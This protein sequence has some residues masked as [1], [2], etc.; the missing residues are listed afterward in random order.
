MLNRFIKSYGLDKSY[1]YHRHPICY[2]Y[3]LTLFLWFSNTSITEEQQTFPAIAIMLRTP[4]NSLS[5]WI[6]NMWFPVVSCAYMLNIIEQWGSYVV[7]GVWWLHLGWLETQVLVN[8]L[9]GNK[10]LLIVL[11]TKQSSHYNQNLYHNHPKHQ[12]SIGK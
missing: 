8:L 5:Y 3:L 2:M 1:A 6:C 9:A 11:Y 7:C 4:Y 10:S 12:H